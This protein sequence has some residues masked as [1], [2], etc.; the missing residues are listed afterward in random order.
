MTTIDHVLEAKVVAMAILDELIA[1]VTRRRKS[2]ATALVAA[3]WG[4][5]QR[6]LEGH[7]VGLQ[8]REFGASPS[9]M[10]PALGALTAL[11][12]QLT[13]VAA[14]ITSISEFADALGDL[15]VAVDRAV[16]V[17]NSGSGPCRPAST[18]MSVSKMSPR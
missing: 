9:E 2:A 17:R 8:M 18:R 16:S 7:R 13:K 15:E 10:Q 5:L 14:L 3:E 11:R 1:K 12:D 6:E 4:H